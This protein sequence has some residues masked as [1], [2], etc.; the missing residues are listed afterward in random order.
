MTLE[1]MKKDAEQSGRKIQAVLD[2]CGES[3]E[4]GL[5]RVNTDPFQEDDVLDWPDDWPERVSVKFIES[6]GIEVIIA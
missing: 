6:L 5:Y 1:E 2:G 3:A 4:I